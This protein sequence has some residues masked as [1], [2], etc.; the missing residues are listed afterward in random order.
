MQ[1]FPLSV[2]VHR[3]IVLFIFTT[4]DVVHPSLVFKVPFD[5]LFNSFLK[6]KARLPTEFLLEFSGVY[7]IPG[8]MTRAVCDVGYQV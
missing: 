4:G 8:V 3:L 6:L 7:G 2:T 5:R 1:S